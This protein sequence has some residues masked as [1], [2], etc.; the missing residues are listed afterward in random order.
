VTRRP[1][2]ST[3]PPNAQAAGLEPTSGLDVSLRRCLKEGNAPDHLSDAEQRQLLRFAERRT[4]SHL[5]Y[6]V[7]SVVHGG[8][9]EANRGNVVA[10]QVGWGSR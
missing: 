7:S 2:S 4:M 5:I 3:M 1:I 10:G 6:A 8:S 9:Y